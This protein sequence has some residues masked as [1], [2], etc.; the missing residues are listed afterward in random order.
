MIR[1]SRSKLIKVTSRGYVTT[2]RGDIFAPITTPYREDTRLIF[3]MLAQQNATVVEVFPDKTELVLTVQ[4][5][6]KD[7]Y[8]PV[9]AKP[10]YTGVPTPPI[11]NDTPIEEE[12]S[13]GAEEK[14][15]EVLVETPEPVIE[16]LQ[17]EPTPVKPEPV[18]EETSLVEE[19]TQDESTE[20]TPNEEPVE[21]PVVE[22][23]TTPPA[24]NNNF[25]YRSNRKDKRKNKNRN[26]NRNN[27]PS[28]DFEEVH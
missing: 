1:K 3:N 20:T 4:N 6:D 16:E 13:D 19:A 14:V 24:Q 12:T 5:F 7:N 17:E 11:F 23:P 15:E 10:V 28:G 18:V 21:E 26:N 8:H 25:E 2:S 22:K 27:Q 9:K